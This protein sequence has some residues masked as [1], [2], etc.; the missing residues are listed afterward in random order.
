[1]VNAKKFKTE[2][3]YLSAKDDSVLDGKILLID[4][5][6][7]DE[8]SDN[9]GNSSDALC[10]RF[11]DV[12]K[13]LSL[14][15]TNLMACMTVWGEDTDKWINHKVKFALT[16]VLYNGQTVKGIQIYPQ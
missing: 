12:S 1:M 16:N 10:I 13:V 9:K 6:F 5:V 4:A 2:K 15:Q 8:I 3:K 14:N 7:E 11:K